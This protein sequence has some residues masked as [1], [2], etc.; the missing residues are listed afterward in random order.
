MVFLCFTVFLCYVQ[1]L[2][3]GA[4]SEASATLTTHGIDLIDEDDARSVPG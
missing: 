3:L 4:L 1:P 2:K